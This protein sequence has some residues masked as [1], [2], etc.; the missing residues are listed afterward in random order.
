MHS[1]T[2]FR[3]HQSPFGPI[4]ME[5]LTNLKS[6]NVTIILNLPFK[7]M[8]C[9]DSKCMYLWYP[10]VLW[11]D[12]TKPV[13]PTVFKFTHYLQHVCN[14]LFRGLLYWSCVVLVSFSVYLS[15]ISPIPAPA[16][17]SHILSFESIVPCS[18]AIKTNVAC[19]HNLLLDPVVFWFGQIA[20]SL[21]ME[22]IFKIHCMF[23]HRNF[24][25]Q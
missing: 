20:P 6:Y 11:T 3:R 17:S 21:T 5:I 22:F 1:D 14:L 19:S 23:G 2:Y 18:G 8:T 24:E 25:I 13:A 9:R 12:C 7:L 15:A 4:T 10:T 16:Q